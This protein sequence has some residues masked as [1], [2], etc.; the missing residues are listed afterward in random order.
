MAVDVPMP[1]ITGEGEDGVVT[2]WFVEEGAPVVEDQLIAEVQAEKVSA[3]VHAPA[4]GTVHGL[5]AINEPVPQGAA[6]CRIT[7]A[8]SASTAG[9]SPPRPAPA[10]VGNTEADVIRAS[11]A[12]KRLA[13]ELGIDLARVRGTGPGGRITEADV[14]AAAPSEGEE[15]G[16]LRAV[17]ARRMRESHR[18]TAAVT[19][20]TVADVTDVPTE[21]FTARILIAVAGAL[22]RHPALN[23]TRDGD[24]FIPATDPV[25]AA[26]VQ[27]DEGLVAP[28]VPGV[29]TGSVPEVAASLEAAARRARTGALTTDDLAG[30][31]FTVTNLGS[32]GI[33]AFTP[34]INPPQI[35]ILGVG[36]IRTRPAFDDGGAVV[37]ARQVTFSLT[38]D[39][40]FVDGAPA[41][42]F[43]S[44]I[45]DELRDLG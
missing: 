17:I 5:V 22:R 36:A 18:D 3:E 24:R 31:T 28:I 29:A 30:A 27:T 23:G 13:R 44:T 6:I 20:T 39:H 21:H 26:A 11:P 15:L 40:A 43:L 41:A 25:V 7:E 37:P 8:T 10:Q 19:L 33:D 12:A 9:T 42:E 14:S 34:I 45:V 2:A 4:A 32:Y 16:G 35:A 38:F 1:V